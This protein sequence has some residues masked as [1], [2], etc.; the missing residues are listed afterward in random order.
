MKRTLLVFIGWLGSIY[1]AGGQVTFLH[2]SDLHYGSSDRQVV[3]KTIEAMNGI[4]GRPYPA[5]IGGL[6]GEPRGVIITGDL[7]NDAN[8]AQWRPFAEDWGL[9][10]GDGQLAWPVCEGTGNHDGGPCDPENGK[11]YVRCRIIE[12]NQRRPNL[13]G[14]SDNGLHYSWDW[15]G[16]HFV[17]LNE[18]AG[19]DDR[20]RY[21]DSPAPQRKAQAYGNPA[22]QSLQFLARD[23]AASVTP[24]QPVIL[25]QHY[26][27]DGFAFRPWGD[28]RAW[29]TEEHALRLWETIEGYNVIA[30]LSGHNGSEDIFNWNG[31]TNYHMDD[32]ACFG[33]YR[34][35]DQTM[36]VG[37]W[38]VKKADWR[39]TTS[40][41][42]QVSANLPDHLA[43]GPYLVYP[44]DPNAMTVC[45][46][47]ERSGPATLEWG[48]VYFNYEMGK[49]AVVPE[50]TGDGYRYRHTITGLT[51]GTRYVY[52]IGSE[53]RYSMG[54]F[55]TAPAPEA[56]QVKLLL[57]GSDPAGD[58][59]AYG[60]ISR[61]VYDLLYRDPACH[62]LMLR[63][64]T[65]ADGEMLFS[66][67]PAARHARY[68]LGRL[69][70]MGAPGGEIGTRYAYP[71]PTAEA[72]SYSFDYGPVHIAVMNRLT[73]T[74]WLRKNL[75]ASRKPWKVLLIADPPDESRKAARLPE[76]LDVDLCVAGYADYYA[77][78][79]GGR[80]LKR[81]RQLEQPH[82]CTIEIDGGKMTLQV[83]DEDGRPVDRFQV[84][85]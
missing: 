75:E 16:V 59:A 84:A 79:E 69:P 65:W 5:S 41:P 57:C 37:V 44:N 23:L 63:S 71:S 31:I 76:A 61:A 74:D 4:A 9:A 35:T 56:N 46:E 58:A 25:C 32:L 18:Y 28:D 81:V 55:Y 78:I 29:W 85:R 42:T 49:V 21:P 6:T 27:F 10:G 33:V 77:R 36:T 62:S 14:V 11:G 60:K 26:G 8:E 43:A 68:V 3:Q 47:T 52:R 20:T 2:I 13:T 51:P 15:D 39:R 24:D 1:A 30:I 38:D 45:W 34:I 66:R 50:A 22:E 48:N 53:G 70:V 82:F 12:R 72:D 19:A 83:M 17:Q 80:E 64:G 67:D 73:E 54:M 7:T 40:Q